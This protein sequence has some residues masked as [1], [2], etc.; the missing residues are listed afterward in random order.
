MRGPSFAPGVAW[1]GAA[2]L[3][4][5]DVFTD[6]VVQPEDGGRG[7]AM[8]GQDTHK[9]LAEEGKRRMLVNGILLAAHVEVPQEGVSCEIPDEVMKW[10]GEF[11]ERSSY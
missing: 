1:R 4:G 8:A 5:E 10:Y 11:S 6:E 7:F 2:H 3:Y 9:N